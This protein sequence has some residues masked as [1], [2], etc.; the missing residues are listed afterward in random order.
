MASLAMT[1]T[2][3]RCG[4]D[5]SGEVA[6]WAGA[7]PVR[8]RCSECGTGFAWADLF[9]PSRRDVAWLVEHARGVGDTARRTPRMLWWTARPRAFWACVG[10]V[11]RVRPWMLAAWCAAV[12]AAL[13]A[14]TGAALYWTT[15]GFQTTWFRRAGAADRHSEA[16]RTAAF[17]SVFDWDFTPD[18][19][20]GF[21]GALLTTRLE[22]TDLPPVSFA[23]VGLALAW[24]LMLGVVP[25]TR[26]EVR[27]RPAHVARAVVLTVFVAAVLVMLE[28]AFA[29]VAISGRG[30]AGMRWLWW[31]RVGMGAIVFGWG[32]AWWRA[33]ALHGWGLREQ[34]RLAA[35]ATVGGLLGAAVTVLA[36][37]FDEVVWAM[38]RWLS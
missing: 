13:H 2:C 19:G 22:G 25:V 15:L 26:R 27:L 34:G 3:P 35:L 21:L 12:I 8:G 31:A 30:M 18:A 7:C 24:A 36:C 33:A 14:L 5:Q 17:T 4:Y 23:L 6:S 16:L 1:P 28:R 9:D 11:V 20:R 32:I 38:W 10:V 37:C 29:A